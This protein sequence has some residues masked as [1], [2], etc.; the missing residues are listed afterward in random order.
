MH[1]LNFQLLYNVYLDIIFLLLV[2]KY[3]LLPITWLRV[4][5]QLIDSKFWKRTAVLSFPPNIINTNQNP[6]NRICHKMHGNVP[7]GQT[8]RGWQCWNVPNVGRQRNW[9]NHYLRKREIGSVMVYIRFSTKYWSV[10]VKLILCY[11]KFKNC[12]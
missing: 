6:L 1:N 12:K 9:G 7:V 11:W 3:I 4:R 2:T 10:F 5:E 8:W